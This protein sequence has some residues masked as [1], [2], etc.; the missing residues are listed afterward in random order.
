MSYGVVNIDTLHDSPADAV[1]FPRAK[2]DIETAVVNLVKRLAPIVPVSR[3][4]SVARH[5]AEAIA[6]QRSM[7]G[8]S[9]FVRQSIIRCGTATHAQVV[10]GLTAWVTVIFDL[11]NL[12]YDRHRALDLEA[13]IPSEALIRLTGA[14]SKSRNGCILAVPHVG[15]MELFVAHLKDRGFTLGFVYKIGDTPTPTERWIYAGRSATRATPIQFARRNT[16][17]EISRILRSGGAVF[18]VVDVYPTTRYKGIRVEVHDAEFNYPPG[19]ARYARSGTLVLPAY[20][21]G[22]D[23]AGFSMN[24]LDPVEYRASMPAREAACD[25]TQRLAVDVG[26]FTAGDPAGYWLWH[27]IPNDPYLKIAQRLRPDLHTATGATLSDDEAAA[28]AV[29]ALWRDDFR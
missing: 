29:E 22:R 15:S 10:D 17:A 2:G 28:L 23:E 19:P 25:F 7:M 27:P 9:M 14:L 8:D 3:Q 18:M 21:S 11:G 26:A 6:S 12:Q 5:I 16:G 20:A 4:P 1:P 24:V 13:A